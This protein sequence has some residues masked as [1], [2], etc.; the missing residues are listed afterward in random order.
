H[1]DPLP[2]F[3]AENYSQISE[4]QV[5]LYQ[6]YT[7]VKG[8]VFENDDFAAPVVVNT[9][10]FYIAKHEVSNKEYNEFLEELRLNGRMEEYKAF[11][12]DSSAWLNAVA[13]SSGFIKHY[14]RHQAY[15]DHPV[16][17]VPFDGA[18]AY[19]SWLSEKVNMATQGKPKAK[20]TLPSREQWIRAA[21]GDQHKRLYTWEGKE[22]NQSN[23]HCN[24]SKKNEGG[25]SSN[26]HTKSEGRTVV[27][28]TMN[29]LKSS[30]S[31]TKPVKSYAPNEFGLY[32]MNGNV[33]EMITEEGM[34]LGGSWAS[35][36]NEVSLNSQMEY[37][38]ANPFVGFRP[39]L[40]LD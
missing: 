37:N 5:H 16:L 39:V 22:N 18:Q 36:R 7:D 19:C 6:T 1:G 40:I 3:I 21:R 25:E 31:V 24:Y 2:D 8:F 26:E 15:Q 23:E 28:G 10:S 11:C 29:R 12:I 30:V 35:N 38:K 27:V 4:G 20:F 14:H 17:N 32:N 13:Y 9:S 34:A 33:A